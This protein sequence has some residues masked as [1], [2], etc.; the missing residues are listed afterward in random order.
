[1]EL[2]LRWQAYNVILMFPEDLNKVTTMQLRDKLTLIHVPTWYKLL[3]C[4]YLKGIKSPFGAKFDCTK[5]K[6]KKIHLPFVWID[7]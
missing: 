3:I 5:I 2:T 7:T 6:V 4:A 1:M